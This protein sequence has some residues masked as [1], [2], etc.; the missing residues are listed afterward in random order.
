MTRA[1]RL[2]GG[3][4]CLA[5]ACVLLLLATDVR[6]WGK[7]LPAD[8]LR[9][10]ADAF[11]ADLWRPQQLVPFH[12]ARGLLGVD[13]DLAYRRAVRL[14]RLSSP[15]HAEAYDTQTAVTRARAEAALAAV[16]RSGSNLPRRAQA[17]NLLGVLDTLLG[18]REPASRKTFFQNA[19][20]EFA[21]A[22]ELDPS[23]DAARHNLEFALNQLRGLSEQQASG[24]DRPG[25]AHGSAGLQQPGRGY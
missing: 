11:P 12:A 10:R 2:V 17:S 18:T 25:E 13:D 7:R 20:S 21:A 3:L 15:G 19:I 4:A 14:F 8:D 1:L 6:S 24:A 5:A 16:S 9:F 23:N 22:S